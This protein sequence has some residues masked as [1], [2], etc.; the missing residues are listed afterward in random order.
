MQV[1]L[2]QLWGR[3]PQ[4]QIMTLGGN[5]IALNAAF[6]VDSEESYGDA[7]SR[8][9][10]EHTARI[11]TACENCHGPGV[12]FLFNTI[13]GE[14]L[15]EYQSHFVR[16][17]SIEAVVSVFPAPAVYEQWCD[18]LNRQSRLSVVPTDGKSAPTTTDRTT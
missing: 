3:F 11:V 5:S 1:P 16:P 12:K 8:F 6:V 10:A 9:Y 17:S 7:L 14:G 13:T 18:T 15:E 4:V 2:D